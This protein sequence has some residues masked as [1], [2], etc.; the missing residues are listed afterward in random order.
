MIRLYLI[1]ALAILC[2]C[3]KQESAALFGSAE[4]EFYS[5]SPDLKGVCV[6]TFYSE[7]TGHLI[8]ETW[9]PEDNG[10]CYL[11]DSSEG[12]GVRFVEKEVRP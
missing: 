4:I 11:R 2:G 8:H 12:E 1:A 7:G 9:K 6:G 5:F 10:V 3:R